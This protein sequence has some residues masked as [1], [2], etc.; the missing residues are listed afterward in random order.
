M[1]LSSRAQLTVWDHF[2]G[3][4]TKEDAEDSAASVCFYLRVNGRHEDADRVAVRQTFSGRWAVGI[5]RHFDLFEP[6]VWRDEN[7]R[8][9]ANP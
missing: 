2:N 4:P 7:N 6:L 9:I 1:R 5:V 3:C 8:E